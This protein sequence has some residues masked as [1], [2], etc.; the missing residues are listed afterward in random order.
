MTLIGG[1]P[2]KN[3]RH[4]HFLLVFITFALIVVGLWAWHRFQIQEAVQAEQEQY[5]KFQAERSAQNKIAPK[6]RLMPQ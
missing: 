5:L 3:I 2:L 1:G 4:K 6:Q